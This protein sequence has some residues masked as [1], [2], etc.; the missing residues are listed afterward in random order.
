MMTMTV[1]APQ[2]KE[3]KAYARYIHVSPQKLRLVADLVRSQMVDEALSQLRFS[4]KNA[5][6]PLAKAI[7]SAVANAVHNFNLPKE[8]LRIKSIMIDQGPVY[9][10]M[11]P[12]AQGR[13]FIIRKRTSHIA[14][15]LEVKPG[16]KKKQRS[17]FSALTPAQPAAAP[18]APLE[19]KDSV[20]AIKPKMKP[21]P[22]SS[23]KVKQQLVNLKRRLFNRKSG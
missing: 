21:V 7:N 10:T 2:P 20:E 8:D 19:I 18:A 4:P 14:V 16:W 13:G 22:K 15:F 23:E 3:V 6:R 11:T 5:A 12:R 1:Q 17:I 9:K